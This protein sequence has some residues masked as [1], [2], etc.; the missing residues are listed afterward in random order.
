MKA[1]HRHYNSRYPVVGVAAAMVILLAGTLCAGEGSETSGTS[2]SPD[3]PLLQKELDTKRGAFEQSAPPEKVKIFTQGV[4][5]VRNLGVTE[6]A[7]NVGDK[8]PDFE[9][10]NAVG[11]KVKL[12]DLLAQ[13]PVVLTW[14][15]G[16]WCP[17]CN[18]QLRA[19]QKALPEFRKWNATLVAISP[20]TPDNSLTTEKKNNLEFEVLSDVDNKVARNYGIVY[21]L[22]EEVAAQFNGKLDLAAYYGNDRNELP[23]AVT[24]VI[25]PKGVIRYAFVDADYRRRAEPRDIVAALE[26]ISGS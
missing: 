8:A 1:N 12:S 3:L 11:E 9:L 22:P 17:Y 25:D 26:K 16:G 18:L 23:L 10:P 21:K 15:R 19:Y 5:D 2:Q 6:T 7:K 20:E 13:G 14:Y 4:E 24:Y